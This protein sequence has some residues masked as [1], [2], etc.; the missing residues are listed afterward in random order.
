ML[1]QLQDRRHTHTHTHTHT[2]GQHHT[3]QRHTGFVSDSCARRGCSTQRCLM[4][5][6]TQASPLPGTP[7][8]RTRAPRDLCAAPVA[9]F[10]VKVAHVRCVVQLFVVCG[11]LQTRSDAQL[12]GAGASPWQPGPGGRVIQQRVCAVRDSLRTM[13][14][15]P[16]A[17]GWCVGPAWQ[18]A[19]SAAAHST[20]YTRHGTACMCCCCTPW[21]AGS[22]SC[23]PVGHQR[24]CSWPGCSSQRP[25]TP[26]S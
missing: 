18:A 5:T 2:Q 19:A 13:W 7:C 26:R 16:A 11:A 10:S 24:C 12:P 17:A 23:S 15:D 14:C 4:H 9:H 22:A 8:S 25:R 1:Y 20:Q 3:Q 6:H 21:L